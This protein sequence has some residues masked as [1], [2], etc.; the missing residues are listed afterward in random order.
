M[1]EVDEPFHQNEEAAK[2]FK[3]GQKR[4]Q[5]STAST[6]MISNP[7]PTPSPTQLPAQP[8]I[9]T[10]TTTT[11]SIPSS[12][13]NNTN[14]TPS[15]SNGQHSSAKPRATP[16]GMVYQQPKS[17][18]H[19]TLPSQPLNLDSSSL[20]LYRSNSVTS[21]STLGDRSDRNGSISSE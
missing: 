15:S 12:P 2:R 6:T 18:E 21:N 16:S 8:Y 5:P 13:I 14:Y 7:L 9:T 11:S 1:A 17:I 4:K 20:R 10:T 19:H 3:H